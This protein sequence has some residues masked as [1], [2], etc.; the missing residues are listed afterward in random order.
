MNDFLNFEPAAAGRRAELLL[1][2]VGTSTTA[3]TTLI[4]DGGASATTKT[5]KRI[6]NGVAL[7][8]GD[9]VLVARISG[10]YV[11]IGKIVL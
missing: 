2:S 8:A 5:Y 10:S 4:F 11:I 6:D 7:A 1:A 9:R 3:G